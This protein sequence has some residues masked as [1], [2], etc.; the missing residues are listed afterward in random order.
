M[1]LPTARFQAND[2]H[3]P[4]QLLDRG[5][6]PYQYQYMQD[7]HIMCNRPLPLPHSYDTPL[8]GY[9]GMFQSSPASFLSNG[10][11][12]QPPL[13]WPPASHQSMTHNLNE[14]VAPTVSTQGNDFAAYC[15]KYME[16]Y[17]I[18]GPP[19][20]V[21][22]RQDW[23]NHTSHVS[24]ADYPPPHFDF[25]RS[26]ESRAPIASMRPECQ[27]EETNIDNSGEAQKQR[28]NDKQVELYGGEIYRSDNPEDWGL[29]YNKYAP[30]EL[31]FA[32][33]DDDTAASGPGE[34]ISNDYDHSSPSEADRSSN[35]SPDPIV[36]F[37]SGIF[38][39]M[40]QDIEVG[41]QSE[42]I[43]VVDCE[44]NNPSESNRACSHDS[45][46]SYGVSES[47]R[48]F[49]QKLLDHKEGEEARAGESSAT[50]I[51]HSCLIPSDKA[52]VA[53]EDTPS[54]PNNHQITKR[55]RVEDGKENSPDV[56]P[57]ATK[58]RRMRNY[59]R[60][61]NDHVEVL[62]TAAL[63]RFNTIQRAGFESGKA[64]LKE[65]EALRQFCLKG[66]LF[67]FIVFK[68]TTSDAC[69]HLIGALRCW[70]PELASNLKEAWEVGQISFVDIRSI[71]HKR[72]II[73]DTR[74]GKQTLR[75]WTQ[76]RQIKLENGLCTTEHVERE[77]FQD[78]SR[79]GI[80]L[81]RSIALGPLS[82]EIPTKDSN[83]DTKQHLTLTI[84]APVSETVV[85]NPGLRKAWLTRRPKTPY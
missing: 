61:R 49:V 41:H 9:V 5:P 7:P 6:A 84:V 28:R 76:F 32:A 39:A 59:R 1:M 24:S 42:A 11:H 27:M 33:G 85:P 25:W 22:Q 53:T 69:E 71:V 65:C 16:A 68:Q 77:W 67:G 10:Q 4:R 81:P 75:D 82:F 60:H 54:T 36:D 48:E 8:Q 31:A 35:I 52:N 21:A 2:P 79:E 38:E 3:Q 46:S 29:V 55:K 80:N 51:V 63:S 18:M 62:Y 26:A 74:V 23:E 40:D 34:V 15:G 56:T 20:L 58:M 83:I 57:V 72:K 37:D 44:D 13:G 66:T 12:V 64:F 70:H 73:C 30:S 17:G 50:G 43:V 47:E 14:A 45:G 78:K 19:P